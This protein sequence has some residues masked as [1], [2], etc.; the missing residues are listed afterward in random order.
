MHLKVDMHSA[1][2][3]ETIQMAVFSLFSDCKKRSHSAK[4]GVVPTFVN[5]VEAWWR[6]VCSAPALDLFIW[7]F[8]GSLFNDGKVNVFLFGFWRLAKYYLGKTRQMTN[9]IYYKSAI[10]HNLIDTQKRNYETHAT[11]CALTE[12]QLQTYLFITTDTD[13]QLLERTRFTIKI[14]FDDTKNNWYCH[15]RHL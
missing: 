15:F 1:N 8:C 11:H 7:C 9:I 2:E 6:S 12:P 3:S 10:K 14:L 13:G 5:A 4:F